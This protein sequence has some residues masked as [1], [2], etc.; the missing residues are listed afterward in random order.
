MS[1]LTSNVEDKADRKERR[2]LPTLTLHCCKQCKQK[3]TSQ[4][5]LPVCHQIDCVDKNKARG[6]WNGSAG[7]GFAAKL[8]SL[9]ATPGTH[10]VAGGN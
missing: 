5:W 8:D 7:G 9:N 6:L 4:T 3:Q 10:V 1:S 2:K